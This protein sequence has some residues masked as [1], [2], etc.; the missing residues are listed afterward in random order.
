MK[1][2]FTFLMAVWALLSLSQ[3]VKAANVTV[4]FQCLSTGLEVK[5]N[6]NHVYTSK[7]TK[8]LCLILKNNPLVK[9]MV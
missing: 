6:D 7:V 4:Y 1:R 2:F 8:K 9:K 3:T 5:D